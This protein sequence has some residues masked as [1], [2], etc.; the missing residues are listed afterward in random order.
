MGKTDKK[1]MQ[2][3]TRVNILLSLAALALA[4]LAI[5]AGASAIVSATTA[6]RCFAELDKIPHSHAGLLL[7]CSKN[8]EGGLENGFFQRRIEAAVKLYR[9]GKVDLLIVSG[10]NHTVGYNETRD[11]HDALKNAGIPEEKLYCDFAGFRTLDSIVRAKEVFGQSSV[12]IIS[13]RFH[14]ERALFIAMKRGVDAIAFDAGE[15][16]T[17]NCVRTKIRE[18]FARVRCVLDLYLFNTGPRFLGPKIEVDKEPG[19]KQTPT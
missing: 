19:L 10:D 1:D 12:T 18:Q 17:F 9:S 3:H 15:P 14:N 4:T 16:E 13:Q 6:T 11:M 5:F 8:L 7:G 2:K